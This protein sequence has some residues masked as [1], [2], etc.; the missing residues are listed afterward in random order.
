[1][2]NLGMEKKPT[3]AVFLDRDGVIL[4]DKGHLLT[5]DA[6][7]VTRRV[8]TCLKELREA[9]YLLIVVTNQSAIGYGWL[10]FGTLNAIHA[11]MQKELQRGGA[12]IDAIY[13]CPHT[14]QDGCLCRKPKPGLFK[15]AIV[16]YNIDASRSWM[17][18][19]RHSDIAAGH[20]IG[21]WSLLVQSPDD[22]DKVVKSI[23]AISDILA[24]KI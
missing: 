19:D 24:A 7:T 20:N 12:Y 3:R 6:M 14:A 1:M 9:G 5:V 16:E 11:K 8:A 13:T 10:T 23:L 2:V 22:L 4:P 21:A 15:Q 17:I 18:G